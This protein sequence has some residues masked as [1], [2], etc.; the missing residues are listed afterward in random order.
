MKSFFLFI[1]SVV[2]LS[3][4]PFT[5]S[6]YSDQLLR[7]E[8]NLNSKTAKQLNSLDDSTGIR[9]AVFSD[10]HQN[11]KELDQVIYKMNKS[12]NI[13]FA[14]YL[15]DMTNTS[16]NFEYDEFLDAVKNLKLPTFYTIGN[17]D[18]IGAGLELF[19]KAFGPTNFYFESSSFRFIF[20]NGNNWERPDDFKPEWLKATVDSSTKDIIIFIHVPLT[21]KERFHNDVAAT[22]DSILNDSKV[23]AVLNGHNHVYKFNDLNGTLLLQCGRVKGKNG[24]HWLTVEISAGQLCTTRMDTGAQECKALK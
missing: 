14:F 21:D 5:S 7:P 19:K 24:P 18:A 4:A 22:F 10:S 6:P 11:Y 1:I 3:C 15:G 13:D 9:F 20:F 12:S 17:H 8:R 23:K 2:L 16:Y